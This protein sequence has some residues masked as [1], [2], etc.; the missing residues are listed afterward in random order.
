MA[1]RTSSSKTKFGKSKNLQ[2]GKSEQKT[3]KIKFLLRK[4]NN[5]SISYR[6]FGVAVGAS[7]M[8][9]MLK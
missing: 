7:L 6:F 5:L 1:Q 9:F 3:I 8:L 4:Q 2:T